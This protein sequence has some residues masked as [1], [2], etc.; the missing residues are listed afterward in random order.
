MKKYAAIDIG[1]NS[2]RLL[3]ADIEDG[4]IIK[5]KKYINPTRIGSAVDKDQRISEEGIVRNIEALGEFAQKARE[6]GAEKVFAIATSAV[7]DA[8]NG[9]DFIERAY[10]ET[11]VT[12]EIISGEEEATLGYQ[13]VV[14]GLKETN[15]EGFSYSDEHNKV[16][17]EEP[18]LLP[19]LVID[20]GGGSTELILGRGD[21]LKKV[22]SLNVGA[23]R[24]TERHSTTD[25]IR[26]EKHREM[27]ADIEQI[28][29]ETIEEIKGDIKNQMSQG[30]AS[31]APYEDMVSKVKLM[32]IGGTITTLAALDQELE[33]YDSDK[34]HNYKLTL[35]HI[36]ALKEK[37]LTLTVE[38]IKNLKGIHPKRA[39]I[40]TAGVTILSIIMNNLGMKEITVSEYDNLEGLVYRTL[41]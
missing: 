38:E 2:M 32:G 31:S 25:P 35:D 17:Q 26:K 36:E 6:C 18:S 33:P 24:M 10:D 20:I 7:R 34:V 29:K 8:S 4:K 9:K 3:L 22:T 41:R 5:R 30:E 11:G 40:I 12:I 27:E 15:K 21:Q 23:V 13:G 16:P 1:T 28:S 39:D 19:I 37:L 14:M